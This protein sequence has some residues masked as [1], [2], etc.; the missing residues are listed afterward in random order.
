MVGKLI[1]EE[2][3]MG[4]GLENVGDLE[5]AEYRNKMNSWPIVTVPLPFRVN[6][7]KKRTAIP[8]LL[9]I[10]SLL[11]FHPGSVYASTTSQETTQAVTSRVRGILT[12]QQPIEEHHTDENG[13]TLTVTFPPVM[14]DIEIATPPDFYTYQGQEFLLEDY[15][16]VDLEI[17]ERQ[18]A[19]RDTITYEAEQADNIPAFADIDVEDTLISKIY[20]VTVP[21]KEYSYDD[22]RWIN[23]FEFFITVE[24]ADAGYYALGNQL[25]PNSEES[26]FSGYEGA[27]LDLIGVSQEA[28]RIESVG[29]VSGS[30]I[31]ENGLVYREAI[32]RGS[33]QV[34]T[35]SAVYEGDV[36]LPSADAKA[37]VAVY[38]T[39]SEESIT[40]EPVDSEESQTKQKTWWEKMMDFFR[41]LFEFLRDRP[42]LAIGIG[43]IIILVATVLILFILSKKRKKEDEKGEEEA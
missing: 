34:A 36:T 7:H 23:D 20:Q 41:Q 17:P 26:P 15:Q 10:S 19:A 33:K 42:V 2:D 40:M 32:A 22:Y 14:P 25:V 27:L 1:K 30:W 6:S 8:L 29:W 16:V 11:L 21:L 12:E 39:P 28:Y 3:C 43:I 24:E 31:G 5:Q 18:V 13:S 9:L 35:V 37:L 4:L 38:K